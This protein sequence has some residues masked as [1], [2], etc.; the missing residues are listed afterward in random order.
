MDA[1][2]ICLQVL[3]IDETMPKKGRKKLKIAESDS[4]T[5]IAEVPPA[6]KVEIVYEDTKAVTWAEPELKWGQ[7]YPMM[8]DKKVPEAILEILPYMRIF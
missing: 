4:D 3:F 6:V 8:V 2:I 5:D 7:I 1:R